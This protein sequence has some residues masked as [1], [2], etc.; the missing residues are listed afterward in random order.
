M[1]RPNGIAAGA[2]VYAPL[3]GHGQAGSIPGDHPAAHV[4][5]VV[6][7]RE[8]DCGGARAARTGVAQERDLEVAV[9]LM[10][11]VAELSSGMLSE[12]RTRPRCSSPGWRTSTSTSSLLA[13]P[14]EAW[15]GVIDGLRVKN[16]GRSRVS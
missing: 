4:E 13:R 8:G 12:P 6:A 15:A 7:G 1:P 2:R 9:E 3:A 14:A 11:A 16:I 10:Q 5:G